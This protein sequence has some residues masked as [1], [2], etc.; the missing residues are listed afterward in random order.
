MLTYSVTNRTLIWLRATALALAAIF[1]ASP[2]VA[3]KKD[4]LPTV[5]HEGL[6]LVQS[7][8]AYAVYLRDGI[9]FSGYDKVALMDCHVA[10]RKNWERDQRSA[11]GFRIRD[12]DILEIK[13]KLA[14]EFRKVFTEELTKK[15]T[16]VVKDSGTGVLVL[17]PAVIN[18]DIAAPDVIKPGRTKTFTTSAGSMTLYLEVFDGVTAELLARVFDPKKAR[19]YGRMSVTNGVTNKAEA[20]RILKQWAGALGDYLQQARAS[21]TPTG[22]P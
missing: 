21:A 4:D 9:D 2:A 15:G 14:T 22:G 6:K 1:V 8:H 20:D 5:S 19:D 11:T 16:T 13:E 10:F 7:D 18:L 3:G 12:E 17:R